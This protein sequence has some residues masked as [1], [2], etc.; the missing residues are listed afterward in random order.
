MLQLSYDAATKVVTAITSEEY[1][2]AIAQK[3]MQEIISFHALQTDPLEDADLRVLRIFS[4]V[5]FR[6]TRNE[7][8]EHFAY[9][10]EYLNN[11]HIKKC[12]LAIVTDIPLNTALGFLYQ[13]NQTSGSCCYIVK[14]FSTQEAATEWLMIH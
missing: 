14:V 9:V 3:Q 6:M 5:T 2:T 13:S 1:N 8:K 7:V 12:I 4:E 11:T 10:Q